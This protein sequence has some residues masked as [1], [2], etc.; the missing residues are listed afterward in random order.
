MQVDASTTITALVCIGG[1]ILYV[2]A[3]WK[4]LRSVAAAAKITASTSF[5]VLAF[6]NGADASAYGRAVLA[7]LILS[8]LGDVLLLSR[9]GT[10][11]LSGIAAFFGAHIAF[12][13]AFALKP[14][15]LKV[16][17]AAIVVT[18]IMTVLLLKW[19]WRHLYGPYK[20][21]VPL[22]MAAVMAMV[23]LA[24]AAGAVSLPH[25]VPIGA[26]AFAFSD[27]SVAQDRFVERSFFNKAWGLPMYYIA[28]VLFAVSVTGVE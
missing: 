12:S 8:W 19:L 10:F 22:Y 11:F 20:A 9:Q 7:A 1:A 17:A 16:L 26:V 25:I 5:V 15:S 28:Q 2:L 3:I 6:V 27:I 21:A 13:A 14:L 18:G 4:G 23:S 24:C